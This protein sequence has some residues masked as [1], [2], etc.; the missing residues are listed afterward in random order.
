MSRVRKHQVPLRIIVGPSQDQ[1]NASARRLLARARGSM[2]FL[3]GDI[4]QRNRVLERN[5]K[6]NQVIL[7]MRGDVAVGFATFKCHGRGGPYAPRFSDFFDVHGASA[8][9]R[10][11]LFWLSELRD[12]RSAFYLYGVK[13]DRRHRGHG[14]AKA[15][16]DAVRD[17]A[18]KRQAAFIELEVTESHLRAQLIYERYGYVAQKVRDLGWFRRFFKF[19]RVTVMR[20]PL[21]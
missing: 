21:D 15:L 11:P 19:S 1:V 3:L 10:F 16:L 8:Y 20:L 17:E 4:N 12:W 14:I 7:A 6:W 9:W 13:V 2:G 18:V 5:L